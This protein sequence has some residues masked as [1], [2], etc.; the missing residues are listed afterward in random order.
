MG[1]FTP[2]PVRWHL[3][4]QI[5]RLALVVNRRD[6]LQEIIGG[7]K[8]TW[9][10]VRVR[11]FNV[12]CFMLHVRS[13]KWRQNGIERS[14]CLARAVFEHQPPSIFS[15]SLYLCTIVSTL[16]LVPSIADSSRKLNIQNNKSIVLFILCKNICTFL[17]FSPLLIRARSCIFPFFFSF[18]YHVR[19]YLLQCRVMQHSRTCTFIL[20][21][22]A[23]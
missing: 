8:L 20:H 7:G 14:Q 17:S 6:P 12:S 5:I 22:Q 15:I 13:R 1:S 16:S 9:N 11:A 19:V 4:A 3:L 2:D 23:S 18:L 21:H 10:P